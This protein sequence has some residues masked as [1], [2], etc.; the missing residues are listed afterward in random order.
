M[1]TL[2]QTFDEGIVFVVI[3]TITIV[4][5]ESLSSDPQK[6]SGEKKKKDE[7]SSI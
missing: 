7:Y 5:F 1:I 4:F 6:E 2:S 3:C